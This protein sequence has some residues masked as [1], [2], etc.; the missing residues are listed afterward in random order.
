MHGGQFW[1]PR[2][3][4]DAGSSGARNVLE[5]RWFLVVRLPEATVLIGAC[6]QS[7]RD[8]VESRRERSETA[9]HAI[10]HHVERSLRSLAMQQLRLG[11]AQ[12]R[13]GE[14][15]GHSLTARG[16]RAGSPVTRDAGR[17]TRTLF[18]S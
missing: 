12:V 18:T 5:Q 1:V 11:R 17:V 14:R 15:G 8:R 2:D 7:Q 3:L 6:A 4:A 9:G 10:E 13:R 16:T